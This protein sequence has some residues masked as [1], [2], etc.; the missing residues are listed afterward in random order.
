VNPELAQRLIALAGVALLTVL[1]S[2]AF[3][4]PDS[5]GGKKPDTPEPV[6]VPGGGWYEALAAPRTGGY[7]RKSACGQIL[8]KTTTGVAHP[9]LPCGAKIFIAYGGK[10]VLTEVVDHGPDSP[11]L[12][13]E[14]L[15]ALAKQL[16][17]RGVQPIRWSYAQS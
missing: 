3:R 6:S 14:V 17:L 9:V 13:F 15:T 11:G 4:S 16:N 1:V 7:G 10:Q 5:D 12:E 8:R 2:L